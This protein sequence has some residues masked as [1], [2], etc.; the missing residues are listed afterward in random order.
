MTHHSVNRPEIGSITDVT[1]IRVGQQN[2]VDEGW[3]TGVTVVLPD[4]GTIAGVDVRGGGPGTAETDALDPRTLVPTADAIVLTGGSAFGLGSIQGVMR[5]C[6]ENG[7]G[8]QVEEPIPT[9]VPIIAGAAI[10]DLGRGGDVANVP[11]AAMAYRAAE[12]AADDHHGRNIERG[13]A[14]AGTGAAL[15]TIFKGGTGTA[16]LQFELDG[17]T[18]VVGAIV[19]VNALGLPWPRPVGIPSPV[20]G[21]SLNTTIAVVATNATLDAAETSRLATVAH[22]GFARALNPVHTLL[23]GDTIFALSTGKIPLLDATTRAARVDALFRV[24]TLAAEVIRLATQD[25]IYSGETSTTS[26]VTLE[27]YPHTDQFD[28]THIE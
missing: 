15:G 27:K 14:G 11:D 7:R 18:V 24:H 17:R 26:V 4:S 20:V 1:G 2:R 25:A 13:N 22:D 3:L 9:V 8:H 23:D 16:S 19:I 10:F 6:V 12:L 5:W 28:W 21:N